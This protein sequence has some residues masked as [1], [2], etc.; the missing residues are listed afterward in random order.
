MRHLLPKRPHCPRGSHSATPA[1]LA[2]GLAMLAAP[3]AHPIAAQTPDT[4]PPAEPAPIEAGRAAPEGTYAAD[5]IDVIHYDIEV[6]LPRGAGEIF[7]TTT[8]DLQTEPGL[9]QAR[10]DFTGLRVDA[11]EV[12]GTPAPGWTHED[13]VLLIEL[14]EGSGGSAR[15][16]RVRY[17]GT[18][19]DG[20]ILGE[21]VHG[22]PSAF[23]DNWPNRARFWFPSADHPSD[24]AT[25]R[26]T[27][28]APA[29][30]QVIA[31]G[32][33][34]GQ[35]YP[36]PADVPG[37]EVGPRRTWV[38]DT[39]VELPSYT[40]V[41]GGA[42]LQIDTVGLAA[43]GSA[44]VSLRTDGCVAV[45][46]WL[47]PQDAEAGAASFRRGAEMVDFFAD[48]IGPFP[49]E[50]LAHVQS[51]TRFGG[52][53]NAAAIFYDQGAI[54]QGADIE[55]TVSHETAHQWFGDSV[56]EADWSELWLSE[57]FAT[58]FGNVF[59]EYADGP[60]AFSERMAQV[61]ERYLNSPDTLRPVIERRDNLF[62]LLNRN[63][64]QKGAA[65]LHMLRREIGDDAFFSGVAEYYRRFRDSNATTPDFMQVM[66]EASGAEL[67]WFFDQWLREPGYP[68][69]QVRSRP[70][71]T[72][73]GSIV[74]IEQIQGEFAPRFVL[75]LTL[76]F[77]TPSG[78]QRRSVRLTEA[79]QEFR[80]SDVPAASAV[81]ID[82]DGDLLIR[83]VTGGS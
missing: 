65:V 47:Y 51:S 39:R 26:L 29:E 69:L 72:E 5:G 35:P 46:T 83:V 55:G 71:D 20:L 31:N 8:I 63:N 54:A 58:Y 16:L 49:Y 36:T 68:V 82:P 6:A 50:K 19:D 75:P 30:W 37:V 67:G 32:R 76:A 78:E 57:G 56:T 14:P 66:Q 24:K 60:A 59:F 43:C 25:A 13:G 4:A 79:R 21:T 45:T 2:L 77:D 74:E 70:D 48:V 28:H 27:V 23:V 80:F 44:P 12:D 61:R 40:M 81:R 17:G 10:L 11:I 64:Y 38:Y 42:D 34:V 7:G 52:M 15:Q 3:A 18:P 33:R 41:V 1:A 53:E 73:T 62:A 9:R 22:Q